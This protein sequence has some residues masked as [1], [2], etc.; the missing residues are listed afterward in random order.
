MY[1][2]AKNS[3]TDKRRKMLQEDINKLVRKKIL[4]IDSNGVFHLSLDVPITRKI[5]ND[6]LLRTI[7]KIRAKC[8]GEAY[9][10]ILENIIKKMIADYTYKL[11]GTVEND[12]TEML[13]Y[14]NKNNKRYYDVLSSIMNIDYANKKTEIDYRTRRGEV[15]KRKVSVGTIIFACERDKMYII[16]SE[17]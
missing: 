17:E 2:E 3:E 13:L 8:Q 5:K 4:S 1:K 10:L 6:I 14:E 9:Q 12:N 7:Y 16:A 15:I 11:E